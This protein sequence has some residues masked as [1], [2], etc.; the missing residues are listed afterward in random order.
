MEF[1]RPKYD[2]QQFFFVVFL[3]HSLHSTQIQHAEH[4]HC[5]MK[6]MSIEIL[7]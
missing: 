1:L 5:S 3:F 7:V 2:L 6:I 4:A